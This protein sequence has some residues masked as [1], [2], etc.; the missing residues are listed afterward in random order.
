M[1]YFLPRV[2]IH[3]ST[4]LP[5]ISLSLILYLY[6]SFLNFVIRG[7]NFRSKCIVCEISI[8][9]LFILKTKRVSSRIVE[10]LFRLAYS[11]LASTGTVEKEKKINPPPPF[12]KEDNL[13]TEG[14]TLGSL[15]RMSVS[16]GIM[17][18]VLKN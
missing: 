8:S 10:L 7:I 17:S 16:A 9:L 2:L 14:R 18:N 13:Q 6:H 12:P 1:K 5:P 4:P 3:F 15:A 11:L